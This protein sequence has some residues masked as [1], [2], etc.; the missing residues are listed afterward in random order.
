MKLH[1]FR[2]AEPKDIEIG[3]IVLWEND[4]PIEIESITR[5]K[6]GYDLTG[7]IRNGRARA[8]VLR[9][10]GELLRVAPNDKQQGAIVAAVAETLAEG[11]PAWTVSQPMDGPALNAIGRPAVPGVV[12]GAVKTESTGKVDSTDAA[13][14]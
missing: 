6:D 4:A 3:D 8:I 5:T 1:I 7:H 2:H 11:E 10:R 14:V 9:P 12:T 13:A